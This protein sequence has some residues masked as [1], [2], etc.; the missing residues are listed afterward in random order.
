MDLR[1][2]KRL[3]SNKA[4]PAVLVLSLCVAGFFC[5]LYSRSRRPTSIE[6]PP[7]PSISHL[8][9]LRTPPP[10]LPQ[11]VS[12]PPQGYVMVARYSGQQ[13][14]G[15]DGIVSLQCWLKT[16]DLPLP[17]VE[18]FVQDSL[19]GA[20]RDDFDRIKFSDVF[21]MANFN[22][23]S[24][25]DEVAELVPWETYRAH[26]PPH[27]ILV[28]IERVKVRPLPPPVVEWSAE[29]GSGQCYVY[30]ASEEVPANGDRNYCFIRVVTAYHQLMNRHAISAEALHG[31]I[32]AGMDPNTVTIVL[33]LWRA[34][35]MVSPCQI[36]HTR[37]KVT[38][39]PRLLMEAEDY[40]NQFMTRSAYVAVMLRAEHSYLM[41][42]NKKRYNIPN[43]YTLQ[44]CL[45]EAVAKARAA[46]A[47]LHT[48]NAFVTA[49][50]GRY[51]TDTWLWSLHRDHRSELPGIQQQVKHAVEE[52]YDNRWTFGQWEDSFSQVTGGIED[53]GYVGALQRAIASQASCVVLLGGGSYQ[54][55]SFSGYLDRAAANTHSRC[56]HYVCMDR[57][58]EREFRDMM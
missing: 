38:D 47:E 19:L 46:M 45:D 2:S 44:G 6:R 26:A 14:G 55:L 4:L 56:V 12:Q 34:P 52:I 8:G 58:F 11:P 9:Q 17:I 15:L 51:G 32:L 48:D 42:R 18:P 24:R 43:N 1:R 30:N 3:M 13:G 29:P 20:L 7:M 50:V 36:S 53:R 22:R 25:S 54:R 23:A 39:S 49:D 40:Q 16:V 10:A 5:Y 37:H 28:K 35:W 31:T 27:A 33:S 21:D 57:S 41:I